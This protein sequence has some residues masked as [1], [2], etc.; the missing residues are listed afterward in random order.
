MVPCR[1]GFG[2]N[3]RAFDPMSVFPA[4]RHFRRSRVAAGDR[5]GAVAMEFAILAVCFFVL[6]LGVSEVAFDLFLQ[7]AT[8]LALQ[9]AARSIETGASQAASSESNFVLNYVCN[10]TAGRLL[11]CSNFHIRTQTFQLTNTNGTATGTDFSSA[12]LST[13]TLPM[14][15]HTLNLSSYDG[16]TSYCNATP[17]SVTLISAIYVGPTFLAG[18]MPWIF[19]E[20]Y[21]GGPVHAVLSQV[22]VASENF[23]WTGVKSC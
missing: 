16:T 19:S 5:R 8:D 21:N 6:F 12:S 18:L 14:T 4:V 13:G 2:V 10:S 11:E 15:G 1:E 9:E 3:L 22:G 17:G 7:E 23:S 20:T